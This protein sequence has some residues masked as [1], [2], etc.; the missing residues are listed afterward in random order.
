MEVYNLKIK[1]YEKAETS[2]IDYKV[3]LEERKPKSWLKSI[4]AFANSKGVIILFGVDDSTHKLEGLD[5]V[6]QVIKTIKT[7]SIHN[8][9]LHKFIKNNWDQNRHTTH[10]K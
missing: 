10:Q 4:S 7:F 2:N 3:A 9:N 1:D 6:Q 8:Q 5:N